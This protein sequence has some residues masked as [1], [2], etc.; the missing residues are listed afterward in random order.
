[1]RSMLHLLDGEATAGTVT[2]VLSDAPSISGP[3]GQSPGSMSPAI[4][5]I[6]TKTSHRKR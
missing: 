2:L 6:A 3:R 4:V 1:M 5:G